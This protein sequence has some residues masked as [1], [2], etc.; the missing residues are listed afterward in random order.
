MDNRIFTAVKRTATALTVFIVGPAFSA[1]LYTQNFEVNPTASWTVNS[2]PTD[3]TANFFFDYSTVGI[4]SAPSALGTRGMKLQANQFSG[5]FGGMSVSPTGQNFGGSYTVRFD[6][7]ANYNGP[8]PAGGQRIHAVVDFRR[9]YER[10]EGAWPGARRDGIWFGAT[11]D[12]NSSS[13]WRA[14]SA[15]APAR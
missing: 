2:S 12:G 11:V 9:G 1:V 5:L 6:W 15:T 4:S 10:Y 8:F 14:Y 3:A 13:D 7:W